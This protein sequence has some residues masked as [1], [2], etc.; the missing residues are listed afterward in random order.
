M[1]SIS[2]PS[3][4]QTPRLALILLTDSSLTGQHL[5]WFHADWT[6]PDATSWSIRGASKS[7]EQSHE[8]LVDALAKDTL[9]Y[10]VFDRSTSTSSSPGTH[11]GS[12]G[13]RRQASGPT[14]PPLARK[15]GDE[16]KELDLRIVGYAYFKSAWGKGYATEAARGLLDAYA[17]AVREEKEKGEKVFYVEAGVDEG[18]P[19]SWKVIE[20][21]G[22][23]NVG[24]KKEEERVWLGGAWRQDGYWVFGMYV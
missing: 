14:V 1:S 22:F 6:D 23:E 10:C 12:I 7:L 3:S 13:L 5:Q 2:I 20:K 16:D 8:R 15:Q 21:L 9:I 24:F 4:I 19:G 18:N 11:L 17:E